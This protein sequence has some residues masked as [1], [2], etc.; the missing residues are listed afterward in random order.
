MTP[1]WQAVDETARS[2]GLSLVSQ[3]VRDPQDFATLFVT[4]ASQRP[5]ALIVLSDALLYQHARQIAE[6]AARERV[7]MTST[8]REYVALGGLMSYGPD[9][10]AVQRK[11][12]DYIDKVL[13]GENPAVLPFEQ[14][15]TFELVINLKSAKTLGLVV[16]HSLLQ[17]ADEVIE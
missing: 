5:D 11:A 1:V 8:F 6:F 10:V 16:P 14:P 4:L 9:L 7:P 2:L 13:K 17:R 15:T 3:P 12:A